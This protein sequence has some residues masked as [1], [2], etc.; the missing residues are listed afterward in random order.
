MLWKQSPIQKKKEEGH[1]ISGYHSQEISASQW[2]G[3]VSIQ[4]LQEYPIFQL[5]D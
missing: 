1:L 3:K 4:C 5:H 2:S